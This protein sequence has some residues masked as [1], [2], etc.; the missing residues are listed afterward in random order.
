MLT[1]I[2]IIQELNCDQNQLVASMTS[3]KF[4]YIDIVKLNTELKEKNKDL[5]EK[6]HQLDSCNLSLKTEILKLS[7][8]AKEK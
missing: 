5:L 3:M 8:L 2:N 1:L 4:E 7:V 6:T